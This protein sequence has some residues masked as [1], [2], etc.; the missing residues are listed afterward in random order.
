MAIIKNLLDKYKI[1]KYVKKHKNDS[2][3]VIGDS[4]TEIFHKNNYAAKKLI[5]GNTNK[6]T[7]I[8]FNSSK[9]FICYHLNA[10]TAYNT[11]NK[12]AT[13][14]T[15]NKVKYLIEHAYL[16]KGCTIV[17]CF[18]EI[19]CR[20]HIQK[21]SE[22]QLRSIEDIIDDVLKN[23]EAFLKMLKNKGY[24]VIAYG[25][26][27]SQKDDIPIDQQFP[28]FGT[29]QQRNIVTKIFN[30]KLKTT[31]DKIKVGY[32]TLFYDIINDDMTTKEEFISKEDYVHLGI[33]S[34][35]L[36]EKCFEKEIRLK[37]ECKC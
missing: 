29:Q 27:P 30:E 32:K 19:D 26:I 33:Q 1:K 25:P 10:V 5:T 6:K 18:G 24:Q 12:N 22:K 2:L 14:S 13:I 31:C 3:F 17:C 8:W 23:Y 7:E 37:T 15:Q 11:D 34:F 9:H 35:P 16:P 36:I 21:Q 28:R 20:I 4:H